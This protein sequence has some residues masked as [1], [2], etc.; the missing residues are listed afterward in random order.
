MPDHV[1]NKA[2]QVQ[3][4]GLLKKVMPSFYVPSLPEKKRLLQI[5]GISKRFINTFDGIRMNVSSFAD[6]ENAKDFDLLEIKNSD[7]Y[8]PDLPHGFFFGLTENE[9]ML[10][11][12]FEDKYFLCFVC[13]NEKSPGVELIGW[14]KLH[15]LI[16]NKRVQY[17]INLKAKAA[18]A[19]LAN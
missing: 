12:V 8:L 3:G 17:Q 9:E 2:K 7:A 13:L 6:V 4:L 19:G 11:K 15:N 18:S 16:R 5:L 1:K 10:L 14:T